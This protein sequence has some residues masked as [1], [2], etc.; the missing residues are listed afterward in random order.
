MI[1]EIS[2]PDRY[3]PT[4]RRVLTVALCLTV[5]VLPALING[6]PLL[7]SDSLYYL[8][9]AFQAE[10]PTLRPTLYSWFLKESFIFNWPFLPVIAQALLT[11]VVLFRFTVVSRLRL[12]PFRLG[13]SM[14]LLG[15]FSSLPWV[16]SY[17]MPDFSTALLV[18]SFA[19]IIFFTDRLRDLDW[20]IFS[21]AAGAALVFHPSNLPIALFAMVLAVVLKRSIR[22]RY[23]G[24]V[25]LI[26]TVSQCLLVVMNVAN[27]NRLFLN[28][29]ASLFPA[30][31]MFENGPLR[32]YLE[33]ECLYK[34]NFLCEDLRELSRKSTFQIL[35][36]SDSSL[37]AFTYIKNQE[38]AD[39]LWPLLYGALKRYP[40]AALRSVVANTIE[41]FI[42][43]DLSDILYPGWRLMDRLQTMAP[44]TA[45]YQ[46]V[47]RDP[48]QLH[49]SNAYNTWPVRVYTCIIQG[50]F[51]LALPGV[52]YLLIQCWSNVNLR[53]SVLFIVLLLIVNAA[54]CG[55][56]SDIVSRYQ[57]RVVWL[58]PFCFLLLLFMYSDSLNTSVPTDNG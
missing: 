12:T 53:Q 4:M 46:R 5:L 18:L 34:R 47:H 44:G 17:L 7:Y 45:F 26:I 13:S 42:F 9:Y 39:A 36:Y 43:F 54:V 8:Y 27:H 15:G 6:L 50:V 30:A 22:N 29:V 33:D 38:S 19:A 25:F 11:L 28:P 1:E 2:I 52:V 23:I 55:V 51:W 32:W 31:R 48:L 57:F 37:N 14:I 3:R 24:I 21:F 56:F 16:T 58:L 49:Y 40:F 41:Q 20:Y 10:H 35:W